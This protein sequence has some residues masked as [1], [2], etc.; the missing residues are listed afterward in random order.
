MMTPEEQ[1]RE[2]CW[3]ELLK[4]EVD[5]DGKTGSVCWEFKCH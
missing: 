3:D 1:N 5:S 4:T 2:E